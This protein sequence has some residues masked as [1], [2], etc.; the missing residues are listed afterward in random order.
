MEQEFTQTEFEDRLK[1]IEARQSAFFII[2]PV[3]SAVIAGLWMNV[4]SDLYEPT[5]VEVLRAYDHQIEMRRIPYA[6]ER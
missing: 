2:S 5:E 4:L 6:K 3:N 1:I